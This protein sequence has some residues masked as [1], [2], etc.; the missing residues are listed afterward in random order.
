MNK[1]KTKTPTG[2]A[3]FLI[4]VSILIW[5]AMA[6]GQLR[7]FAHEESDLPADPAVQFGVMENGI[8]YAILP[9]E[10]PPGRLSLR[11]LVEAGSYHESDRQKGLAHLIEHMAFNGTKNFSAGEMVEYFQRLGMA[12]GPDT[13]AHTGFQETVYKLELPEAGGEVLEQGLLLLRDYADGMLLETEEIEKEKGVV[14]SELRDRDTPGYRSFVDEMEFGLPQARLTERMPIGDADV[15]R[16]ATRQDLVDF[17]EK[18]YTPDRMVLI[19]VGDIEPEA[20][21][22]KFEEYFGDMEAVEASEPDPDPGEIQPVARKARLYSN[23]ELGSDEIGLYTRRA[24]GAVEDTLADRL[25]RL[26]IELGNGMLSRRFDRLS[27]EAGAPITGG[28]GYDYRW[29]HF[30]RYSGISLDTR[31]ETWEEALAFG[32]KEL[33]RALQ[34]GFA[35]A[36]FAEVQAN[37]LNA[38]EESVRQAPTRKSRALSSAL[39][40]SVRDDTVFMDPETRR[41]L[42]KPALAALTAEEAHAALVEAWSPEERLIYIKGNFARPVEAIY[43]EA[44]LAEVEPP[45]LAAVGEF[46]YTDFGDA[47]PVVREET[48]EDLGIRKLVLGN[49]VR[50]NLKQTEYEANTIQIGVSFGHGQLLEPS[51]QSGLAFLAGNTFLAGGLG[52]HSEDELKQLTAGRTVRTGFQ[53]EGDYFRLSGTTNEEDMLLQLQ[54]LAAYVSDPGFRPEA[55]RVFLR[56]L[57][58]FYTRLKSDPMMILR[59][60]VE[61]ALAGGDPRFGF[62]ERE[63]LEA[64]S[65]DELSE[66]MGPALRDGYMEVAVVG[67]FSDEEAIIEAVRE[68]LGALPE[69]RNSYAVHEGA[70]AVSVHENLSARD[71]RYSTETNRAMATVNWPTTGQRDIKEVR[72]LSLLASVFSDRMRVK[73]REAIGEAYSP[74]A[75]NTSSEVY[76][77]FGYLRAL[78]GVAPERAEM[79]EEILLSIAEDLVEDGVTEDELVRAVEPVKNQIE[80]YRRSNRYWLGSVLQRAQVQPERLEWARSFAEFWDTVTV[81]ELNRLADRYL[82]TE[83]AIP[84]RVLPRS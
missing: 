54:I 19:G 78:V 63:T 8:R 11:L 75:Y 52:R 44:A 51:G 25:E 64:R 55:R 41:D 67:D 7:P 26:R 69:R 5:P 66:W 48:A 4:T 59:D 9:W 22:S 12:F 61:Q 10:E 76:P 42:L 72:R 82:R 27:K 57:D 34:Y 83:E 24:I 62:P 68:T 77:Q 13:N 80:E 16:M 47:S 36:E 21:L 6:S 70:R 15:V 65:L 38:L 79:I 53:V 73:I 17:Y 84:V 49:G 81:E 20:L 40:R 23:S 31:S 3:A 50:L 46:G 1:Q 32:T 30:V 35:E 37:T 71:F 74:Y 14:L 45:E 60:R 28:R 2:F 43:E 39:V 18:W 29:M 56:Q 33:N 58:G